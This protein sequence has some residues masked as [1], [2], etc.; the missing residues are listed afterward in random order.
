ML[1]FFR[2]LFAAQYAARVSVSLGSAI[3]LTDH[4]RFPA[5]TLLVRRA[6]TNGLKPHECAMML[7]LIV[8]GV[9]DCGEQLEAAHRDAAINSALSVMEENKKLW[10]GPR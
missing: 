1:N 4:T 9:D 8:K 10:E 5:F 3:E 7:K 2:S 6:R